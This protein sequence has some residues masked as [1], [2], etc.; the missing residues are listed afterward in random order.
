[1]VIS[2]VQCNPSFD[3]YYLMAILGHIGAMKAV[4]D[5]RRLQCKRL[6]YAGTVY[7]TVDQMEQLL[8][9]C[10]VFNLYVCGESN[11]ISK[12]DLEFSLSE[13]RR[14]TDL[15]D[16]LSK[17]YTSTSTNREKFINER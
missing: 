11:H 1:M 9:H 12:D 8:R 5:A 10:H 16:Y 3:V 2:L 7:C 4:T 14:V 6:A 13:V 17:Q 15:K